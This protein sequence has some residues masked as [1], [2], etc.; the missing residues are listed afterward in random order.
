MTR[1]GISN[2][3]SSEEEARERDEHPPV[4]ELPEG[5][6]TAD[7]QNAG[8]AET[9]TS[10]KSGSRSSAQKAASTRHMDRTMPA[11]S[12]VS[13]AFGLEAPTNPDSE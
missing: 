10:S 8:A 1:T 12:K 11:S 9:Q 4:D 6:D 3:E 13:G 5:R 7:P 2:R